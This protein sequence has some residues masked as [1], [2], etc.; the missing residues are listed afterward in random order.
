MM[1]AVEYEE[2][3]RQ[4]EAIIRAQ[5]H[6]ISAMYFNDLEDLWPKDAAR[7]QEQYEKQ[8]GVNLEDT[9]PMD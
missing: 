9:E 1:S 4:A 3:L 6:L 7:L 8:Y 5:N 2:R